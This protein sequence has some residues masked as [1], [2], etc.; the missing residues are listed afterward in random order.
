MILLGEAGGSRLELERF[1]AALGLAGSAGIG[2]AVSIEPRARLELAGG[3]LVI[4]F[5]NAD[6]FIGT[7]AGGFG[8]DA[9]MDLTALWSPSTGLQIEG[10]G[11]IEIA[12][13][14]H[15]AL[16]PIEIITLYVRVS[17]AESGGDLS[18]PIE[19]SGAFSANLGVLQAAVDRIGVIARMT[20]PPDG[21]N[22]GPLDL[23]FEFKPPN[24]IGLS[25]DAGIV[26]G[27]GYLY[28]DVERGEYA[29]VLELDIAGIVV[30]QGDRAHHDAD[31]RRLGRASRC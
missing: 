1:A 14:T 19:L 24:G 21:G 4:D 9:N 29:G 3:R 13:P 8:I 2:Q 7:I 16:G 6:G 30:G 22:L 12:I 11:G 25:V 26:R 23:G 5:S 20:F 17:I 28:I 15:I 31:A 10:S 27:G 18:L